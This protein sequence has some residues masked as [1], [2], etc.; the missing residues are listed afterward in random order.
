MR[1]IDQVGK[2]LRTAGDAVTFVI[3][4][5][6]SK[7]LGDAQ[8]EYDRRYADYR[9][10]Y[11]E[12]VLV[13]N[14][15][16]TVVKEIGDTITAVQVSLAFCEEVLSQPY[17]QENRSFSADKSTAKLLKFRTKYNLAMTSAVGGVIGGSTTVGSWILVSTFGAAG[18]LAPISTLYGAAAYNATLAWFGGGSLAAGGAGMSGGMMVLGGLFA[19]PV[20]GISTIK[21]YGKAGKIKEAIDDVKV[22][23]QKITG[24]LLEADIK[25]VVATEYKKKIHHRSLEFMRHVR[26]ARKIIYPWGR[27]SKLKQY[28]RR[29]TGKPAFSE[30][31]ERAIEQLAVTVSNYLKNFEEQSPDNP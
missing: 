6:G 31:Q 24:L 25:L 14:K 8:S 21:A 26:L 22:E 5:G 9:E 2:G 1:K 7:A 12:S 15:I 28:L 20:F 11:D 19:A 29:Q 10:V 30:Q 18:T 17:V 27:W 16:D 3:T 13:K 4:L 23:T